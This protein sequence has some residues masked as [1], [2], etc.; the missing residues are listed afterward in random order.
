MSW[1]REQ[2]DRTEDN[3]EDML[4]IGQAQ[5]QVMQAR[6]VGAYEALMAVFTR[7]AR[8]RTAL[9]T[10]ARSLIGETHRR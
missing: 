10:A 9:A 5:G 6:N 2:L 3:A 1:L 4:L 7:A 8:D